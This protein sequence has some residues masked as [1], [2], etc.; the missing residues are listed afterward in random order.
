MTALAKDTDI[1]TKGYPTLID[2]LVGASQ[3][4]YKGAIVMLDPATGL[5]IV[6]ADTASCIPV[7]IADEQVVSTTAGVKKCRV[8]S[9]ALFRLPT[10]TIAQTDVPDTLCVADSGSLALASVTTNDLKL[11]RIVYM[12]STTVVW[13]WIPVTG[14]VAL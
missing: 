14:A 10:A 5:L 3:T 6:G 11:G 13:V 2:Y 7:G 9:G 8:A 1:L 4:I 12:E